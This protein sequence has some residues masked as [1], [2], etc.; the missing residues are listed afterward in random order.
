MIS[1]CFRNGCPDCS[2]HDTFADEY[3]QVCKSLV[4]AD[5]IQCAAQHYIRSRFGDAPFLSFHLR[6][7]DQMQPFETLAHFVDYD[8]QCILAAMEAVCRLHSVPTSNIFIATN[9]KAAF[10]RSPLASK[11]VLEEQSDIDTFIE[12]CIC[13]FSLVFVFSRF[14]DYRKVAAAHQR[15]TWASFVVDYRQV[16]CSNQNN[17]LLDEARTIASG[18]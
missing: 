11:H 12:Q 18:T 6:Y 14:N 3:R 13:I 15:S 5:R 2:I 10:A 16:V 7:P 8:E 1:S 17:M 9:N 4:F